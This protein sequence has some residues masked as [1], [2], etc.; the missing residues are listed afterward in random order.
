M[1]FARVVKKNESPQEQQLVR[2]QS[3]GTGTGGGQGGGRGT[4]AVDSLTSA[5]AGDAV[6]T[7][8][9]SST[10]STT[11][12]TTSAATTTSETTSDSSSSQAQAESSS[13]AASSSRAAESSA[14]SRT[15][16]TSAQ[17]SETTVTSVIT[18]TTVI[19][20][21]TSSITSTLPPVTTTSARSISGG[22]SSSASAGSQLST[23]A[24]VGIAVGSAVGGLAVLALLAFVCLGVRRRKRDKQNAADNILWPAVGDSST[25]YPEQVHNTGGAGFGVGDDDDLDG[26][27]GAYPHEM[28]E[29]AMMGAGAAGVGAAAGSRYGRQPTLP[30]VPPSVYSSEQ[31]GY[32]YSTDGGHQYLAP[33]VPDS[34]A[35]GAGSSG[36]NPSGY[37]APGS[38]NSHAPLM[39]GGAA[40]AGALA[41]AGGLAHNPSQ[42]RHTPS[43]PRDYSTAGHSSEE[44]GSQLPF[45]G[46][47]DSDY[48]GGFAPSAR[49]VSPTPMQ[50]GDTFGSGY[51]ETDNGKRWRLSVV[52]DD[53][54]DRD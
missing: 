9:E 35:Y 30:Q 4:N 16:S 34:S 29:A 42:S 32:P 17:P 3:P 18:P 45:P 52:N 15:S 41:G 10:T 48:A 49:P 20:I 2:R 38:I 31:T 50:V 8:D 19:V 54:R 39:A 27:D 25:L 28:S 53:P 14:S 7:A 37:S 36:Y 23:G 24:K 33:S 21:G 44:G 11:S 46:E 5:L 26:P 47:P 12:Q 43:P 1:E 51:D 13:S 40:G 6:S 22:N